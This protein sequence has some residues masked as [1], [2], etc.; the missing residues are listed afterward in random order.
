[1]KSLSEAEVTVVGAGL[2]GSSLALA[3]RGKVK[4]VRGVEP[5]PAYWDAAR[6]H[7]DHVTADLKN[8]VAAADVVILAA[9]IRA[10][11]QLLDRLKPMLRPGTLV[12]DLGSTKTDIVRAMND[13]PEN[14]LAVGGHPMTGKETSG[15]AGAD[16]TLFEGRVFVLC[17][18]QRSTPES[19]AFAQQMIQA[20]RARELILEAERHDA[21]V[22]AISHLPYLVSAGLVATVQHAAQTDDLPWKL[23][24]TGFRDTSR[25]AGS[26]V[27]MMGD[28][29]LTNRQAVL[30]V[31]C[32]FTE[33]LRGIQDALQ[34][35][36]EDQ[37]RGIL[38]SAQQA[39][40]AWFERWNRRAE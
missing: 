37:L 20:I 19:I 25:L 26:D 40:T 33:Q 6:P 38:R 35:S 9:P 13:L 28:T 15:P 2:M 27:T 21:A 31:L 18:T 22:A 23:A 7:F 24:A 11:L 10:I 36:D 4:G 5:N 17:P 12:I 8:A 39:R 34:T 30:D 29:V 3:L 14:V 32:L 16:G 1:M